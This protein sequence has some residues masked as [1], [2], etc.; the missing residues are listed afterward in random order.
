MFASG[1]A[2]LPIKEPYGYIPVLTEHNTLRRQSSFVAVLRSAPCQACA[3]LLLL[4]TSYFEDFYGSSLGLSRQEYLVDYRNDWSWAW[5]RMLAPAGVE[6]SIYVPTIAEGESVTTPDGRDVRFLPLGRRVLAVAARVP[7]LNRTPVG[8]YIGQA[9]N[10]AALLAPL[11][12]SLTADRV[13]VLIVQEYWTA[14]F[15]VLAGR[16]GVP[17]VA[18]DQG[19]P[20]RRE[21]KLFKRRAFGRC[22]GVVVQTM[23]EAAKVARFGG[24]PVRIPNAVDTDTFSPGEG[25]EVRSADDPVRRAAPRGPEAAVGRRAGAGPVAAR[26]AAAARR[27]RA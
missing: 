11:R 22:S 27:H 14:R 13:D 3:P 17:V 10:A 6:C 5:C 19:V 16:L 8:R 21:I 20:D 1:K 23:S 25:A 12:E 9:A 2:K 7:V 24:E 26:L 4:S 18:V 15:D